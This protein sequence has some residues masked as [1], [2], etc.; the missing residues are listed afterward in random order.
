MFHPDANLLP[1]D[2]VLQ[3]SDSV[4]FYVNS[5]L[6]IQESANNFNLLFPV[7]RGYG[8]AQ[9]HLQKLDVSEHSHVL[10]VILHTIYGL[11]S[12]HFSPTNDVLSAAVTGLHTYGVRLDVHLAPGT[13]LHAL[14]VERIASAPLFY[15][16]LAAE[17]DLYDIASRASRFLLGLNPTT[18]PDECVDRMGAIYLNRLLGLQ[19]R[20]VEAMKKILFAPPSEHLPVDGCSSEAQAGLAR[21]WKL[22]AAYLIWEARPGTYGR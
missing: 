5:E 15:Y 13:P 6:L 17:H 22:T 12:D 16:T 11:P 8:E 21:A 9:Q 20:R 4:F 18:I 1:V 3:S 10:N 19:S 2:T 7:A 14:L